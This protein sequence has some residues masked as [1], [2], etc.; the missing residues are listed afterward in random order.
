MRLARTVIEVTAVL[1][2]LAATLIAALLIFGVSLVPHTAS[3]GNKI[4]VAFFQAAEFV[5][6]KLQTTGRAPT[7]SEFQEWRADKGP[8]ISRIEIASASGSNSDL[9]K[10]FGEVP[11]GA[12]ILSVWRGEWSEYYLQGR[13]STIDSALGLYAGSIG[14]ALGAC[15]LS[16]VLWL[17]ARRLKRANTVAPQ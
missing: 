17:F 1:A 7:Q 11:A 14:V 8:W 16:A 10:Q 12:Y 4:E 6:R 13:G 2:A 9:K 5:D 15:S 3:N